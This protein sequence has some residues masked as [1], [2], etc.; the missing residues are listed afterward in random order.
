MSKT[1]SEKQ[2]EEL[3]N[4]I[5]IKVEEMQKDGINIVIKNNNNK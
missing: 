5:R 1:D 4:E 3:L 2:R